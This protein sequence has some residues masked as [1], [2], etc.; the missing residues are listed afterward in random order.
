MKIKKPCY[1]FVIKNIFDRHPMGILHS[2]P[3]KNIFMI[4]WSYSFFIFM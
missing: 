1:N 4:K 2:F 3:I